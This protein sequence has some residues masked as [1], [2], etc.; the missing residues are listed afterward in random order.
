MPEVQENKMRLEWID[1]LRVLAILSVVLC[2]SNEGV[3]AINVEYLSTVNPWSKA[4][5]L[6]AATVGRLGVPIFLMISG[7]LLLDR[8]YDAV[9]S[10]RFWKDNW[11]HLLICIQIWIVI[12]EIFLVTFKGQEFNINFLIQE[13]LFLRRVNMSH[14]W[15]MPMI[16]GMYILFPFVANA[17]RSMDNKNL[18]FPLIIYSIYAFGHPFLDAVNNALHYEPMNSTLSL[19]FSGGVYGIYF[20]MGYL[21]KKN[22]FK[23]MNG[24][25]LFIIS[26]AAIVMTVL[27][28]FWAYNLKF[29]YFLWY[30]NPFLFIFTICIFE[31]FSRIKKVIAYNLIKF[32]AY[33]SFAVYLIHNIV[34][35]IVLPPIKA[36]DIA[37]P[38][39]V[40]CV[41]AIAVFMSILCAWVINRIP[42]IGKYILFIK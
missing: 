29:T 1:L 32:L 15:Y 24:Y 9:K 14:M 27:F 13:L 17:L 11:L 34:R 7:Y 5:A 40:V 42:K 6:L 3:Y 16:L 8:E 31:L 10:K 26:L 23:R 2:H 33:Y 12:Y 20:I 28:Q 39:K 30:D 4:F 41:W 37:Q 18:K 22:Y 25:F 21:V 19:G 36:L 35:A 38:I